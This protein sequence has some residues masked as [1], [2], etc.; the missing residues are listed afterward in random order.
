MV[1]YSKVQNLPD[2]K[3]FLA[4]TAAFAAFLCGRVLPF[5]EPPVSF[6]AFIAATWA[7]ILVTTPAVLAEVK[8]RFADWTNALKAQEFHWFD[9][10]G[11][12]R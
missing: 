1:S 11:D 6:A 2:A 3:I 7:A 4:P 8:A 12:S 9:V 10:L 5:S